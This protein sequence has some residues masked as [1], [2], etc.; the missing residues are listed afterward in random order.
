MN[1]TQTQLRRRFQRVRGEVAGEKLGPRSRGN[2]GGVVGRERN[3]REGDRQ[4]CVG[5]RAGE[6][7][8]EMA[9]GRNPTADQYA[10]RS[11]VLRGIEGSPG[12]VLDDR[13]L[14]A[15]DEVQRLSIEVDQRRCKR[16]GVGGFGMNEVLRAQ[17]RSTLTDGSLHSVRLHIAANCG[18]D[19]A[20]GHIEAGR[21]VVVK[22]LAG[23]LRGSVAARLLFDLG[24]GKQVSIRHTV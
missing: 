11:E 19:A 8:T 17:G 23:E 12:K 24:K 22:A 10:A 7:S 4:V 14:E 9:V 16:G 5:C 21:I 18:L 20:K 6:D 13:V 2:H 15:C 3:R 1:L